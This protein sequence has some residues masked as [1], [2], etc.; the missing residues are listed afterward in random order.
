MV[1][2]KYG[3]TVH[4]T[5]SKQQLQAY[6]SSRVEVLEDNKGKLDEEVSEKFVRQEQHLI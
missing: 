6:F 4:V 2:T 5:D 3:L 1:K